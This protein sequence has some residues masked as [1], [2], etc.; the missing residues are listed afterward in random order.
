VESLVDV[1][2]VFGGCFHEV[3]ASEVLCQVTTLCIIDQLVHTSYSRSV[4]GIVGAGR[5]RA[6][7]SSLTVNA[8]LALIVEV[9]L[10]PDEHY[11]SI[12]LALDPKD[13][14]MESVGFLERFP[15]GYRVHQEE[16]FSGAHVLVPYGST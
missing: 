12:A 4:N 9:T 3:C 14:L 13:L 5:A 8:H 11:W 16:P 10:G 2:G 1:G 7:G 15:G 6:V